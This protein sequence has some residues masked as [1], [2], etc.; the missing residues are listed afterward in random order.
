[1]DPIELRLRVRNHLARVELTRMLAQ[2]NL[3]LIEAGRFRDDMTSMIIHDLKNPLTVILSNVDFVAESPELTDE[4]CQDALRDAQVGGQRILRLIANLLDLTRLES[5]TMQLVRTRVR[6]A[7]VTRRLVA[8]RALMARTTGVNMEVHVPPVIEATLDP[9][10]VTRVMENIVDNAFRYTPRDGRIVIRAAEN[11]GLVEIL[12]GNSGPAIPR[13]ARKTIF[14]KYG[15]SGKQGRMNLGL[16]LY[17]CRLAIEA[18]NGALTVEEGDG[19]P[20]V[21]AIRIPLPPPE[22]SPS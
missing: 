13:E 1:V 9:D 5:G 15:Q 4:S 7:D 11:Q 21:F 8:Q 22:V 19:L 18:H 3:E 2:R 6:V 17:F 16:G 14:E 10:L 20:T 12:I